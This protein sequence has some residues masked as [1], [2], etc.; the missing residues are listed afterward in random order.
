MVV[1]IV[2]QQ[3]R[4]R[5]HN[6]DDFLPGSFGTQDLGDDG[7][8]QRVAARLKSNGKYE[9][10]AWRLN[11]S[12]YRSTK[13]VEEELKRLLFKEDITKNEYDKAVHLLRG[14]LRSIIN[15]TGRST[16]ERERA[17]KELHEL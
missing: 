16:E 17:I 3:L 1:E 15:D 4:I 10:Q 5:R 12:K 6:P 14:K 13:E 2:G 11:L 7:R 9:T 8:L